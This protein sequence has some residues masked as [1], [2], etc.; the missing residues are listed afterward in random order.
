MRTS[1]PIA[2]VAALL[3]FTAGC[4]TSATPIRSAKADE[5]PNRTFYLHLYLKDGRVIDVELNAAKNALALDEIVEKA[6]L[7]MAHGDVF[8]LA[9]DGGGIAFPKANVLGYVVSAEPVYS[10][11][12]GSL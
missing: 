6:R 7:A 2:A 9:S 11:R 12:R 1:A 5:S 4:L 8:V 10:G 3:I